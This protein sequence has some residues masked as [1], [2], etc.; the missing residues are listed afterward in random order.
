GS[1]YDLESTLAWDNFPGRVAILEPRSSVLDLQSCLNATIGSTFAARRAGI[2][3]A[4]SATKASNN[5]IKA[6]V[7]GS[8]AGTSKSIVAVRRA[9]AQA[10]ATPTTTPTAPNAIPGPM[11]SR[12]TVRGCAPKATRTPISR[13][14][15]VTA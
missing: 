3:Q 5:A 2:Q 1:R 15:C 14:R 8:V 9:S 10:A 11:T 12:S 6:N 7:A 13:V 4:A